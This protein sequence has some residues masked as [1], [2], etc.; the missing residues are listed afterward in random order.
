MLDGNWCHENIKQGKGFPGLML[1]S[2]EM[3]SQKSYFS[4]EN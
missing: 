3:A 2:L 4:V 1:I